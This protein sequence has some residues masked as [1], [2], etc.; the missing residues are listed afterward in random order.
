MLQEHQ[1]HILHSVASPFSDFDCQPDGS[2]V[3]S[4]YI[5][6]WNANIWYK[7]MYARSINICSKL[8]LCHWIILHLCV[9]KL[10]MEVQIV[11]K[12]GVLEIGSL[13]MIKHAVKI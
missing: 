1:F 10:H 12:N 2:F 13:I 11:T 3:L 4:E 5:P 6:Y 8:Q 9:L 7:Q